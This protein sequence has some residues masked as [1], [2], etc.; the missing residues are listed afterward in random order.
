MYPAKFDSR[1]IG[2]TKSCEMLWESDM[3]LSVPPLGVQSEKKTKIEQ[4][5]CRSD[6]E[7][8]DDE[9]SHLKRQFPRSFHS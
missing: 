2:R 3:D 5:E 1:H 8:S 4:N 9:E 6:S 7:G